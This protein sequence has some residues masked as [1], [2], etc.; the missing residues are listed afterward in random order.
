MS[1]HSQSS[2]GKR[3]TLYDV[4]EQAGVSYQ[5]VSRVINGSP[6]VSAKTL[7]RVQEAIRNLDYQPNKAAQTLVTRRSFTLEV[8]TAG[9]VHYGP[10][11][12]M[13][14]VE[15]AARALGYKLTFSNVEDAT[16]EEIQAVVDTFVNVD[17]VIAITPIRDEIY[18]TLTEACPKPFV[19]IGAQSGVQISSII[20]DQHRGSQIATQHLIDLGHTTIA[21]ITGPLHWYDAAARHEAFLETLQANHLG[22]SSV[23]SADWTAAGGYAA[24]QKLFEMANPFTALVVGNDQMALGVMRAI[25]EH[26]LQIPDD[27]SVVGFDDIPEAAYFEPP[28]TT[29]NQD[30]AAIGK[31]SVEYLVEILRNPET[32]QHQRVLYP[33][34]VERASTRSLGGK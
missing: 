7:K 16:K 26:G 28:L 11:Q 31:Q 19:K 5:T 10:A 23:L 8:I 3:A 17:G 32:P 9:T 6:H 1:D 14:S 15:Q 21:E 30:F 22:P 20:I 25:R 2:S 33:R 18:E 29:I 34:F 24:A 27:I 4:A 12:M 13:T